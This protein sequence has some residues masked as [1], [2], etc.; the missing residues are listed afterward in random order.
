M[1]INKTL[2]CIKISKSLPLFFLCVLIAY[3]I[4]PYALQSI[5]IGLLFASSLF[6]YRGKIRENITSKGFKPFV[7]ICGW[8]ILVILTLLYSSNFDI[9]I[10]RVLRGIN[11]LIFPL[12]FLYILPS[13]PVKRRSLIFDVFIGVH[14]F[15]IFFLIS[16]SLEGIDKVGF[17]GVNGEWVTNISDEGFLKILKIFFDM[18]FAR[19]RYFINENQITTF[20]IH[21][22]YLSMGFVWCVFLMID[23]LFFVKIKPFK[24]ILFSVLLPLFVLAIIYFTSIP[25]IIALCILLPV[26]VFF[27]IGNFRKRVVYIFVSVISIISLSQVGVIKD[28]IFDDVRLKNDIIEVKSLLQTLF[29]NT[30]Y[31]NT[32]I[33]L[34]VWKCSF[35][36][37]RKDIWFGYGIGDEEEILLSCYKSINC[38]DCIEQQLNTHNYYS[39]LLLTGGVLT[40]IMFIIALVYMFKIALVTK[41]YLFLVLVL[42][43]GINLLSENL[44]VRIH[45]ILFYVLFSGILFNQSYSK[46]PEVK[47]KFDFV[48]K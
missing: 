40:L 43:I 27:K 10:K 29:E 11:L 15:L 21:K 46:F 32:N 35:E 44:L 22:A 18:S 2:E 17:R 30:S 1:K 41:N 16:K 20:F 33:R 25:N 31:E 47:N 12:L 19:S 24:R 23:R 26:F 7:L 13:F 39:S 14:V 34:E 48:E 45:G 6:T 4:L 37:I 38:E 5:T 42:L 9:G 28:R 8:F 3:P 36:Q